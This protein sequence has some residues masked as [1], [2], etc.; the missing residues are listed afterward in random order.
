VY[1]HHG[2]PVKD[3]KPAYQ[4]DSTRASRTIEL[5]IPRGEYTAEWHDTRSSAVLRNEAFHGTGEW[6]PLASPRY[7]EDVALVVRRVN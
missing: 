3:A 1:L 2:R 7:S 4:V 5:L 6:Q